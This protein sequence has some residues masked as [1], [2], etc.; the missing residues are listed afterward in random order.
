MKT[1]SITIGKLSYSI[2]TDAITRIEILNKF[3]RESLLRHSKYV[4]SCFCGENNRI[5]E[6]T[7][8][9]ENKNIIK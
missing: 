1:Y 7:I 3:Y 6:F 4:M 9:D 2:T 8:Y 5:S